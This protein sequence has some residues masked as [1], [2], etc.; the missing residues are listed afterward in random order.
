MNMEANE[1]IV[2]N[3][4]EN[5]VKTMNQII[6]TLIIQNVILSSLSKNIL[7]FSRTFNEESCNFYACNDFLN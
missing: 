3:T 7:H 6:H 5:D 4:V 2:L 1:F